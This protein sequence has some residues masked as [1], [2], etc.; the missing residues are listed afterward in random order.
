MMI[1]I[2]II[3][4]LNRLRVCYAKIALRRRKIRAETGVNHKARNDKRNFARIS[5]VATW[6]Y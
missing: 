2:I 6:S 4:T 3:N 5:S 1:I